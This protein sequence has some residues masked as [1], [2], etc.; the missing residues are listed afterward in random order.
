MYRSILL[1]L[2]TKLEINIFILF[3]YN[4]SFNCRLKSPAD[5]KLSRVPGGGV[6][7]VPLRAAPTTM[8]FIDDNLL[9]CPDNDGKMVDLSCLVSPLLLHPCTFCCLIFGC[10]LRFLW[11]TWYWDT[12][13]YPK[14]SFVFSRTNMIVFFLFMAHYK[15]CAEM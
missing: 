12:L 4:A 6:A 11:S 13:V 2:L 15:K 9:W 8:P 1:L 14:W 5:V 7:F 3:L 10:S